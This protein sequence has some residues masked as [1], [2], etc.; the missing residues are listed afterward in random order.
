MISFS[1][2]KEVRLFFL[3]KKKGLKVKY[4]LLGEVFGDGA[5]KSREDALLD[6]VAPSP[7]LRHVLQLV[8]VGPE[9]DP[10]IFR[11]QS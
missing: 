9:V 8:D 3:K 6:N 7:G 4:Y 10:R 2:K 5:V 1:V 11:E